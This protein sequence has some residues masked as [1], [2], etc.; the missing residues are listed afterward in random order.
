MRQAAKRDANEKEIVKALA[1]AGCS[2]TQLSGP[3]IPDLL[4]SRAG[5]NYLLEIKDPAQPPCKQVLTPM[6]EIWHRDWRGQKAVVKTVDEAL[7]AVGLSVKDGNTNRFYP[8][9]TL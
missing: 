1:A 2:V 4:V 9:E 3:G 7:A 6:Q 5:V 8:A